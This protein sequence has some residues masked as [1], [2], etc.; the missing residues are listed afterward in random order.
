M[1]DFFKNILANPK[2][3]YGGYAGIITFVIVVAIL[4]LNVLIQ[5]LGWQIDMTDTSV[6]T[7]S[8]QTLDILD[9]LDEDVSIYVL[10]RRNEEDPRIMEALDRYARASG[11]IRIETVD[12]EQ[13]PAFVSRFDPEGE[14]LRNGSVIVATDDNFRAIRNF[15]LFSIDNRNPQS[16]QV[17]GLNVERRITNALIF[18]ATGR[19]PVVYQTQ[20]H[21]EV[22]LGTGGAYGRLGEQF[23]N[24]NLELQ[25]V[26]LA[27]ASQVPEDGAIVAIVRPRTDFSESEIEKLGEFMAGG[28]KAFFAI[29]F[30]VGAVPNIEGLLESYGI[31]LPAAVLLEPDRNFNAGQVVQLAPVLAETSITTPLVEANYRV[32]TP[33]ARPVIEL[34]TK[35]R[36]VTVEAL[37]TT[38]EESFYRTDLDNTSPEMSAEDVPGPHPVAARAV[39]R[40]F[41][42]GDEITRIVVVGDVDFI[43]LV[44]QVNG[45]LDFLMNSFGWLEEQEDTLSIRPKTTLQFPMQT[46]GMQKLIFGGLFVIVIPLAILITGLVMWLR[47]RHL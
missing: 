44:D 33:L 14:G 36:G 20:G 10:A 30:E 47:R 15:D 6:Y 39:E 27:T 8:R 12:A 4:I 26:N 22:D 38:S 13:N 9:E 23:E 19:T 28:G 16:P 34:E 37:L 3:K 11:R 35:P 18:V 45:N 5:Q 40:E 43:S 25:T 41:T 29:D 31:G 46:T 21:G 2:V 1:S 42:T 24:A 17:L 32:V 7:L